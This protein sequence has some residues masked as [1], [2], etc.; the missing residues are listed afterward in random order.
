MARV[1]I[2]CEFSGIV[3]DAFAARGHDAW[4]CDLEPTER[5]GQHHQGD[6]RDLLGQSWDVMIAFPPCTD[7]SVIGAGQW[8]RKQADGRQAAALGFV[9]ELLTAPIKH[10]ALENPVGRI[11][12]A[13]R[14]PDQI[15][16]PY[17]F[18]HPWMK[19]TCLWLVRLPVLRPTVLVP[20]RGHW[21]D[22]GSRV[23]NKDREYGDARFGSG[24]D[25]AR[26]AERSRTFQG[27]ADAMADQW[28][29]GEPTGYQM[30]LDESLT[31]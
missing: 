15:I 23:T 6:V 21:V 25:V 11:S 20:P 13:I 3:R 17:Q 2:A 5:P 19:R 28:G 18:G 29:T 27:I 14:Q 26:K 31:C 30:T 1:L 22:G 4:S 16:H 7:L 9:R 12:T 24:T 8:A 10:I